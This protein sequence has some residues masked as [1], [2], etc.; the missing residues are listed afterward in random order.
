ML[1][2][3]ERQ[4]LVALLRMGRSNRHATAIRLANAAGLAP[5]EARSVLA[6]LDGKGFAD[7]ERVRLTLNGLVVAAS[8]GA[9]AQAGAR[10][11]AGP[12]VRDAA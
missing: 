3:T 7:T 4:V 6:A 5:E 11:S 1:N 12:T 8:L 9:V 2:N 10:R